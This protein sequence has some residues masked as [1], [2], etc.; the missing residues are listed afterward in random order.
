MAV[1]QFLVSP[2]AYDCNTDTANTKRKR[3]NQRL[4][5]VTAA[6]KNVKLVRSD[7]LFAFKE[8]F[9]FLKRGF[10]ALRLQ[11]LFQLLR[12]DCLAALRL[13]FLIRKD[14]LV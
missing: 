11:E 9:Y 8:G 6:G 3:G 4:M 5:G 2:P 7:F 1:F 12:L 13:Q 14:F 10:T